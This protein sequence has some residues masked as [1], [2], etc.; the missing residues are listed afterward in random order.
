MI[1][2][3][4]FSIDD[5]VTS[6]EISEVSEDS[7]RHRTDVVVRET[8]V[9]I[10]V[11]GD[12]FNRLFCL[13]FQL[14]ELAIGHL[15]SNGLNISFASDIEVE[16]L[17]PDVYEIDVEL[18]R[19][20]YQSLSKVNSGLKIKKEEVFELAGKLDYEGY[21]YK[22]TGGT[23]VAGVFDVFNRGSIFV[24]D[25]SRH[26][27]IDKVVGICIKNEIEIS[28]S[29]LVS[30]CRQTRSTMK[31]EIQAG[32][33]IIISLSAPTHLAINDAKAFGLM[34][35]GFAGEK[36]FNVYSNDWRIE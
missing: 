16:Q 9:A 13:P 25:I 5:K 20:E 34:L 33:P 21:L 10:K 8:E 30:S 24:E 18:E 19:R 36:K 15:K 22:K 27:A 14:E 26:C 1:T 23:H 12:I 7:Q 35:I 28:G 11:N 17:N 29:V 4:D 31:K 32:F 3:E 6:V 2:K